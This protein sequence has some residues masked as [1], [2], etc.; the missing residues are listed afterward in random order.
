MA[1]IIPTYSPK[2]F[3][4]NRMGHLMI[5]EFLSVFAFGPGL[6]SGVFFPLTGAEEC[7]Y[8]NGPETLPPPLTKEEGKPEDGQYPQ[9]SARRQEPSSPHNL[10]LVVYI[11]R[12]FES[13]A[14]V[15]EDLISIGTIGLIK[16]VNT[17]SLERNHQT[18][19]IRLPL[20]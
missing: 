3:P 12:K 9:R 7:H 5:T 14:Q 17:F 18:G 10:R 11:A 8:I 13:P 2:L 4:L 6:W 20:H 16:A 1:Y 15:W 19:H